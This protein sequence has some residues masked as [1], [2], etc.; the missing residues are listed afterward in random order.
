[1][2]IAVTATGN[3]IDFEI[4]PR[5]GRCSWFIIVETDDMSFQSLKNEN[6]ELPNGAGIQSV[7]LVASQGVDVVLTGRLGP[8]AEQAFSA[9]AIKVGTGFSGT[10]RQAV[11]QY[12]TGTTPTSAVSNVDNATLPSGNQPGIPGMGMGGGRGMGMGGRCMGG[13]GRGMGLGGGRG[14]GGGRGRNR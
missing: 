5:F 14:M 1:M 11:E 7:S 6:A 3:S 2:K 12:Q 13:S 10:V 9:T 4:D 8:K